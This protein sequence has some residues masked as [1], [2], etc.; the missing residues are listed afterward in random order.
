M[1]TSL[2]DQEPVLVSSFRPAADV[3]SRRIGDVAVLVR[4][5]TNRIYELNNTG[6]RLWEMACQGANRDEVV[7]QVTREFDTD[8]NQVAAEIDEWL[9]VLRAEGLVC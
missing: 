1:G 3:V 8:A 4:L 5:T 6:A 7:R 2:M 9:D